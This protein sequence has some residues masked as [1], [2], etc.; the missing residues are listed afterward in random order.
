MMTIHKNE[1][2]S[3]RQYLTLET[4]ETMAW[5]DMGVQEEERPPL[6]CDVTRT[7]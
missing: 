5:V 7:N 6:R 2:E 1:N 4:A 3:A